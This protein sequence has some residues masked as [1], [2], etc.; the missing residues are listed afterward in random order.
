MA[1]SPFF[2]VRMKGFR[3][4][5]EVADAVALLDSRVSTLSAEALSIHDAAGR[6]L[7]SEVTS[8]VAVPPFDRAAMD[9]YALRAEETFGAGPYSPLEFTI[10]GEALPARPFA[11]AV[12]AGQAV[13]IM[14]GAPMPAGADAVLQAEA[15]EEQC[16]RLRVTEPVS[17][18]RHV[19]RRGEDIAPGQTVLRAGRVLRPQDLG[20]LAS[21]G[22]GQA[23][24]V[25]RPS[26][27]IAVTGDE[28]L[29]AG[30]KPDDNRIVDSNSIML[31]ALA[32]RDG[33]ELRSM[34]MV[35]DQRE[36]IR[37]AM[38]NAPG[39]A[40]L[41]SGGSSVGKEDHAPALLAEFGELPVHGVALRPASP[42]GI[43]FLGSKVV[44]LL[45]GNPVSCLCA[46]DLFAGRAVRRLGGRSPEMP[47]RKVRLPL[48]EKI[49]SAVG[50]VDYVRVKIVGHRV[51]PLAVSGAS[52]LSTTTAADGFVLVD[53]DREG[54]APGEEVEVH[55]Y[56]G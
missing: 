23:S 55:L 26:V 3:D 25:R 29:P 46:Y 37:E 2:D 22:V 7:A 48:A 49:V 4:R 21:I 47:Y 16:G 50:R 17:P 20:L 12:T 32:R 28:L 38:T 52:M 43:G 40:L 34:Q 8:D 19:G 30:A 39:E 5:T 11:G 13:R 42:S 6:V 45:P 35:P 33:A 1:R 53:R 56:D 41:V 36:R 18:Q 9:G 51:E 15:A 31:A 44:F 10:I 14:T 24:V 27:S 54:H